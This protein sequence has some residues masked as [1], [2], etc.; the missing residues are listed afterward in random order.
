M[1]N[2]RK[3]QGVV[4]FALLVT[5]LAERKSIQK[6]GAEQFPLPPDISNK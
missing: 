3:K 2:G 5:E 4:P 6:V 1:A